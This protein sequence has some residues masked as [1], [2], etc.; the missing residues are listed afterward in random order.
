MQRLLKE[1][2]QALVS[3]KKLKNVLAVEKYKQLQSLQTPTKDKEV[4]AQLLNSLRGRY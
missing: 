3:P 2:A 1:M 4:A